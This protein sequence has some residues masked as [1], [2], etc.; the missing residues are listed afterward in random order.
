MQ[1]RV[2]CG[3]LSLKA[4]LQLPIQRSYNEGKFIAH[5][6][7]QFQTIIYDRKVLLFPFQCQPYSLPQNIHNFACRYKIFFMFFYTSIVQR[8]IVEENIINYLCTRK[9]LCFVL[10][11]ISI[12]I[13]LHVIQRWRNNKK[14]IINTIVNSNSQWV[15]WH[16][17][18]V[19]P[20]RRDLNSSTG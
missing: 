15:S 14:A 10:G 16:H 13:I 5:Q 12:Y 11:M 20:R 4:F 18:W 19:L 7:Y 17:I 3:L 6:R 9:M 8:V 1:G 2:Y